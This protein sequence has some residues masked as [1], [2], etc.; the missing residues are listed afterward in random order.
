MITFEIADKKY[1]LEQD[2]RIQDIYLFGSFARQEQDAYSDIDILII[3]DNCSEMEYA[4]INNKIAKEL[5][6]PL[7]WISI[8]QMQKIQEMRDKGSYFLWHIK[9][10]GKRLYTKK[11]FLSEVLMCL[12][13]YQGVEDDLEDYAIIC[14]DIKENMSDEYLDVQYELSILASV[15]RNT[16]IC[17]DFMFGEKVFGRVSSVE[18]CNSFMQDK[19]CIP[20]T[21]YIKLYSNR[22]FITK[23]SRFYEKM[24]IKDIE[25]WLERADKLISCAKEV[26]H[27]KRN[28]NNMGRIK[29]NE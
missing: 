22:L 11:D 23:K 15:I 21:E 26:Y 13:E 20:I 17:I 27:E 19:I 16:A 12:P 29:N 4:I 5:Q 3:I 8:Y 18:T 1:Y 14:N 9:L 10:E 28:E 24:T 7:D 25:V 2:A 6:L